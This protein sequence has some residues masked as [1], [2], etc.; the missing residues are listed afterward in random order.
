MASLALT[1][2]DV[3]NAVS[4]FLGETSSPGTDA[5]A[6]AKEIVYRAYRQFLFPIDPATGKTHTWSFLKRTTTLSLEDGKS[7]Y[8]LPDDFSYLLIPFKYTSTQGRA[9]PIE[10]STSQI[11]EMQSMT[12]TSGPP[13]YFSIQAG[14]YHA[15]T[16]QKYEVKFWPES[17]GAYDFYFTYI[18][19]PEKPVNTTDLFIGG[20]YTSEVILQCALGIAEIQEEEKGGLQEVK[21][22]Q[23]LNALIG[24]DKKNSPKTLGTMTDP[25]VLQ[26]HYGRNNIHIYEVTYDE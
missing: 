25:S 14:E 10:R 12:P 16:G 23:M 2:E 11:Y 8:E 22:Q 26:G 7:T 15:T 21:A 18:I 6:A 1:F 17:D 5:L 19:E 4:Y 24:Y 9:N 13:Q 3:Y 20:S